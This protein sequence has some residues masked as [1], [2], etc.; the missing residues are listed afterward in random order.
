MQPL[1]H[2]Q[3]ARAR[4][5][6]PFS[7]DLEAF[8]DCLSS[9]GYD[10][11]YDDSGVVRDTYCVPLLKQQAGGANVTKVNFGSSNASA[12]A[13]ASSASAS[14]GAAKMKTALLMGFLFAGACW[15]A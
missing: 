10:A 1:I 11:S 14:Q 2:P 13:S 7:K 6:C 5:W 8:R 3:V 15:L 9:K 4:Q 12:A